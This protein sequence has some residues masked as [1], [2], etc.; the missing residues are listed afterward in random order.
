MSKDRKNENN[1]QHLEGEL[2]KYLERKELDDKKSKSSYLFLMIGFL[3]LVISGFL[4]KKSLDTPVETYK[5]LTSYVE[6]IRQVEAKPFSWTYEE[7]EALDAQH[8]AASKTRVEDIIKKYGA[9]TSLET[10][11]YS[12]EYESLR[13]LYQTEQPR[14]QVELLFVDF[15]GQLTLAAKMSSNLFPEPYE[16]IVGENSHDWTSQEFNNLRVGASNGEGGVS[17]D[18]VLSTY[19]P[20]YVAESFGTVDYWTIRIQYLNHETSDNIF[21]DFTKDGEG[22]YQLS[23]KHKEVRN[24]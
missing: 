12:S 21:L 2:G 19:G 10:S 20:V 8:S 11:I 17:L 4:Y 16:D 15:G 22:E 23:Q 1:F 6:S 9:P 5:D 14:R 18:E 3:V 24:W 7:F 13:L